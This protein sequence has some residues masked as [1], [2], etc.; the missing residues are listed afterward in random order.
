MEPSPTPRTLEEI[1]R[2]LVNSAGVA[3]RDFRKTLSPKFHVVWVQM[4]AGYLALLAI[5]ALAIL[6]DL[7]L[8][9]LLPLT[10]VGCGLLFGYSVSYILLFFHEAYHYNIAKDREVNDLMAN[11]LIGSLVG[12]DIKT[13]RQIHLA[14]HRYLGTPDDPE[15]SYFD[16]LTL[17]FILESL[18]GIR[19]FKGL[20]G[21]EKFIQSKQYP[22]P[23]SIG[24][25]STQF[26]LGVALNGLIVIV[27]GWLGYWSLTGAWIL[28]MLI[29]FP[30]F[31]S[32]RNVL[33]HRDEF[34]RVE[35]DYYSTPRRPV[36]RMFGD[37]LIASTFGGAGFNRHML[38]HWEPQISYTR[39]K[40]LEKFL[41]DTEASDIIK[42]NHPGYF[43]TFCR[44][45]SLKSKL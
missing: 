38:H 15:H 31:S 10:I 25:I 16:P 28:G 36:T 5:A 30:L 27:S 8:P 24:V 4:L 1:K 26:G 19:V 3:F 17:R 9:S 18:T 23:A 42:T 32:V 34:A 29:F 22:V 20:L 33:E 7:Y 13:Y 6:L 41:L 43:Q 14:H 12:Q 45:F 44:V 35:V 21:R 40:D 37:G 2:P 39:L 11:L